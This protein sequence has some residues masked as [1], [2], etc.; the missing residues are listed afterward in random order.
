M[1][2][3]AVNGLIGRLRAWAVDRRSVEV[4]LVAQGQA[5]N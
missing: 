1:E 4:E 2:Y 5:S 3:A